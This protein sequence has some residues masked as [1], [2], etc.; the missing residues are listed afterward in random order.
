M[1]WQ[2]HESKQRFS[3]LVRSAQTEGPQIVT[4]HGEEVVVVVDITEY[5]RL[6]GEVM[7]F[8]EF[9][10]SAP[11]TELFQI[12]RSRETARLIDLPTIA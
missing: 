8:R 2:L 11:D 10:R 3:E 7:D 9:L 1:I 5:R 6:K 4:R 12:E